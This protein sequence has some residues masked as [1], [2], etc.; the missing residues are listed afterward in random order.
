MSIG[1]W[2]LSD[3]AEFYYKVNDFWHLNDE[4]G[5]AWNDFEIGIEWSEL[6]VEYKGSVG[7]EEYTLEDGLLY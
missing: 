1:S 4:S 3:E 7:S 6:R 5:M 2:F